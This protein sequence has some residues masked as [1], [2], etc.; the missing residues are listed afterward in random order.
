MFQNAIILGLLRYINV[1][2]ANKENIVRESARLKT[3]YHSVGIKDGILI[4]DS[5]LSPDSYLAF[6]LNKKDIEIG[7]LFTT[8]EHRNKKL[9]STLIFFLANC[10]KAN[11]IKKIKIPFATKDSLMWNYMK[12]KYPQFTWKVNREKHRKI[13]RLFRR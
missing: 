7:V 12:K 6:T 10:A 3:G 4:I 11:N 13:R 9:A 1:L 2:I 5:Y 8:Y